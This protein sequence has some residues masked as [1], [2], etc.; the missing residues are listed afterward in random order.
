M[1]AMVNRLDQSDHIQELFD[2]IYKICLLE[3]ETTA[4]GQSTQS[5]AHGANGAVLFGIGRVAPPGPIDAN[6]QPVSGM[7]IRNTVYDYGVSRH[8]HLDKQGASESD[9]NGT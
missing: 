1:A 7:N 2:C 3:Q 8:M 5:V 9:Q 6:I 4:C